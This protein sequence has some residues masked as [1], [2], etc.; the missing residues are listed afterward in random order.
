MWLTSRATS[1]LNACIERSHSMLFRF[2]FHRISITYVRYRKQILQMKH[3]SSLKFPF[4]LIFVVHIESTFDSFIACVW[5]GLWTLNRC[6]M[7]DLLMPNAYV[8]FFVITHRRMWFIGVSEMNAKK[9][10]MASTNSMTN[11]LK[12]KWLCCFNYNQ[13]WLWGSV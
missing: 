4:R 1:T 5:I 8:V 6:K 7:A 9:N 13:K 12:F 2:T 10:K 3:N 11:H